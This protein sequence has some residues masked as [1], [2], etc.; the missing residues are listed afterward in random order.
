MG[1]KTDMTWEQ[2][3]CWLRDQP[4]SED[5]VRA[6]YY[7][8]PLLAAAQRFL[9]STEWHAVRRLMPATRGTALDIG[10]GRG[11][12]SYALA[13]DGWSVTSLEPD[14]SDIVG[15]GA[16]RAL[17]QSENLPITVVENW[18][19]TLPFP[20]ASF[21]LVYGRQV[22]HHAYDLQA[23]CREAGRVLKPGGMFMALREHVISKPGDVDVF[24]ANHPLHRLYGGESAFLLSQYRGAIAGGGI[25]LDHVFNPYESDINLFP[26]TMEHVKARIASRLKMPVQRLIPNAV[27]S[28]LG[29]VSRN[30]G[31]LYSFVGHKGAH[32]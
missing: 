18:G 7:D 28:L 8:D 3:V 14:G 22:L 17:Q 1:T 23:L 20:D 21:D 5:L 19:E 11:I 29:A 30:P 31:R 2:A 16:I 9:A 26:T 6:C 15:A 12:S 13:K 4:H 24:R 10:A 25:T 32:G 27:L